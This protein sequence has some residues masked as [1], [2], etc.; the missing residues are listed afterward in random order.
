MTMRTIAADATMRRSRVAE[1][2]ELTKPRITS[3]VLI[4]T[5]V[6]FYMGSEAGVA[7]FL[8]L[9]T[10][11]GTALVAGGASALNQYLERHRDARMYRTRERPLP[12]GR[13]SETDALVFSSAISGSGVLYLS[14]FT[15]VLTGT[16][17]A[18]TLLLYVFLYTPLKTRTALAT[19]VGAI[20]GAA[21]PILGWTAAGGSVDGMALAL[22]LIVFLWQMPHFL[23]IAWLYDEDYVRGGFSCLTIHNG[24]EGSTSRQI[25]LYCCALLPISLLPTSFGV[26]GNVYM[27]GALLTS[28]IYLGYGVGLSIFRSQ[29]AAR[30]LLKVSV[31]YLPAVFLLMVVDKTL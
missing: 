28:L 15:S 13:I 25:I 3:L 7:G 23:A 8:L 22:F 2:L 26:T 1:Y 30:R 4:T 16:L 5:L 6:G 12:Q 19:L 14:F 10:I 20:P 11:L 31:L 29:V 24:G 17:A 9:H 27:F 18:I 21:P